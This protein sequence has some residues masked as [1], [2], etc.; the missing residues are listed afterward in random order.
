MR[1]ISNIKVAES[2]GRNHAEHL[3]EMMLQPKY[4]GENFKWED[5]PRIAGGFAYAGCAMSM[6]RH[7]RGNKLKLL[8]ERSKRVAEIVATELVTVYAM[9]QQRAASTGE[10]FVTD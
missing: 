3:F 9:S 5:L 2:V 8:Q 7:V 6:S 10:S 4:R 1:G